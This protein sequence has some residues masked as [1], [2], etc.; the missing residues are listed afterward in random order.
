M[1]VFGDET[2][3]DGRCV[4]INSLLACDDIF[5]EQSDKGA[6]SDGKEGTRQW[7]HKEIQTCGDCYYFKEKED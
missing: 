7:L 6:C 5:Y 4:L 2:R 3:S 1:T